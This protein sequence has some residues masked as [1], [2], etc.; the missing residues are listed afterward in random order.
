VNTACAVTADGTRPGGL[1]RQVAEGLALT[2][3]DVRPYGDDGSSQI[4]I[5]CRTG[6]CTLW[7]SDFGTA[8]WE[9]WPGHDADP[10]LAADLA[11]ILLT[12][13]AGASRPCRVVPAAGT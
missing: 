7:V 3:L 9:Y 6:H 1:I 12:G 2:G 5:A 4:D 13:H 8:E 11:A 10:G